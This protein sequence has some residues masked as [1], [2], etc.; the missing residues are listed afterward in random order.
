IVLDVEV[1]EELLVDDVLDEVEVVCDV[2]VEVLDEVEVVCDVEVEVLDEVEVVGDVEAEVL[3]DVEVVVVAPGR[4]AAF[5]G[6]VPASSSVRSKKP[7]SSR[8]SAMRVP[9]PE[10]TH[11]Y[12]RSWPPVPA[13]VRSADSEM[14]GSEARSLWNVPLAGR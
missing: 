11:V 14:S 9:L 1:D 8:S 4:L 13:W 2:E 7:S 3:D 10:G 6:S 5:A 12:V